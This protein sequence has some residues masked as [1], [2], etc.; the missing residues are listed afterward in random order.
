V[1][2]VKYEA[3]IQEEVGADFRTPTQLIPA[4]G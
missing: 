1:K 4:Q 3:R 2:R